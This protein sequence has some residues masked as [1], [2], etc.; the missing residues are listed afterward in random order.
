MKSLQILSYFVSTYS[1]LFI[2]IDRYLQLKYLNAAKKYFNSILAIVLSWLIGWLV[3][4][5]SFFFSFNFNSFLLG[6]LFILTTFKQQRVNVYF[7][8]SS[9]L[10]GCKIAFPSSNAGSTF[11]FRKFRITL[12]ITSQYLIPLVLTAIFYFKILKLIEKDEKESITKLNNK[13]IMYQIKDK[14]RII[15]MLIITVVAFALSWLPVHLIHFFN[16]FIT[17]LTDTSCN[18]SIIYTLVYLL[19]ISSCCFNPFI[20]YWSNSVFRNKLTELFYRLTCNYYL[21]KLF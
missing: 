13:Q 14:K 8:S 2:S 3:N 6:G 15:L 1:M 17:P 4:G 10:I 9:Q 5:N 20:Y 7:K 21:F 19:G 18:A 16:F 12:L 11:A